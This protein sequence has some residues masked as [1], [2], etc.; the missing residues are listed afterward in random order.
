M[1]LNLPAGMRCTTASLAVNRLS[2]LLP[3]LQASSPAF[4]APVAVAVLKP[5]P[6]AVGGEAALLLPMLLPVLLACASFDARILLHTHDKV[7]SLCAGSD[8]AWLHDL[9]ESP[10]ALLLVLLALLLLLCVATAGVVGD[11]LS[12]TLLEC[13]TV[14]AAV[15]VL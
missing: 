11:L 2:L 6:L 9:A 4:T 7:G 1:R 3:L 10:L 15:Q 12:A 14:D 13:L 5:R 8:C